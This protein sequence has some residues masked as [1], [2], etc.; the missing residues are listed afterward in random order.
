MFPLKSHRDIFSMSELQD[1]LI[2]LIFFSY[3]KIS[4]KEIYLLRGSYLKKRL[5]SKKF[6]WKCHQM[7]FRNRVLLILLQSGWGFKWLQSSVSRV[8]I[9]LTALM[10]QLFST[11][12]VVRLWF[13]FYKTS[14]KLSKFSVFTSAKTVGIW[15]LI[16]GLVCETSYIF[17]VYEADQFAETIIDS[18]VK[19]R[20]LHALL[21]LIQYLRTIRTSAV[22]L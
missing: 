17:I 6:Y 1:L 20:R 5:F 13:R 3:G 7:S 9:L 18:V 15:I 2:C 19:A 11:T 12:G 8:T 4:R 22:C 10:N 21:L 14:L 16:V